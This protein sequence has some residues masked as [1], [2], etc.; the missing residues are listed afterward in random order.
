MYMTARVNSNIVMYEVDE[1]EGELRY[2]SKDD[3]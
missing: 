2:D 1:D 3:V